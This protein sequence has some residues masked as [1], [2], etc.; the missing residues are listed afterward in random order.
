MMF[1]PWDAVEV[2]PAGGRGLGVFARRPIPKGEV[3]ERVPLLIMDAEEY[4]KGV[5]QSLLAR[6]VF[7]W[8]EGRIA[9]AL[10]YGSLYNHSYRPNAKYEDEEPQAKRF[11]ALKDIGAGEEITVNYN[12]SPKSRK[13]LWF[14]VAEEAMPPLSRRNAG[15]KA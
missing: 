6:Y 11:V 7:H 15:P 5:D 9:L 3:I 8:G 4:A 2:K 10:G 14:D 1:V 12:G 13:K